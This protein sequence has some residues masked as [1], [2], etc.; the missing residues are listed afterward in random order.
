[1]HQRPTERTL[2][3]LLRQVVA[4]TRHTYPGGREGACIDKAASCLSALSAAI[5]FITCRLLLG[6][7]GNY[8][9]RR[10]DVSKGRILLLERMY[11]VHTTIYVGVPEGAV[12][13]PLEA[14]RYVKPH[15]LGLVSVPSKKSCLRFLAKKEVAWSA[16]EPS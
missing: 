1:M 15:S 14:C 5:Y 2:P 11:A 16:H 9:S 12:G 7:V 3:V 6:R 13:E 4:G 10:Q 8:G